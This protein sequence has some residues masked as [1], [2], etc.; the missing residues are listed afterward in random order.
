MK[1]HSTCGLNFVRCRSLA[2]D[3]GDRVVPV[4]NALRARVGFDLVVLTQ[5]WHPAEHMS[6][7]TNH[8]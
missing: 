8:A 4:I 5:D 7:I 6:F 3:E 2:V 1:P